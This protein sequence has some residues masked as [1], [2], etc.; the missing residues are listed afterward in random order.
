MKKN[1]FHRH[2]LYACL[3]LLMLLGSVLPYRVA[4]SLGAAI[5]RFGWYVLL[6]RERRKTLEH[7]RLA[8]GN[9]KTEAEL[10]QIGAST[11]DH[12]GR[13][14]AE[15]VK[16]DHLIAHLDHYISVEGYEHLDRGFEAGNGVIVVAAHFGNW[17]LMAGHAALKGYPCSVIARKLYLEQ[18]DRLMMG[19]RRKMKLDM[20]YRTDSPRRMLEVLR[21]NR[22]LGFVVDQAIEDVEVIQVQFFGKPAWTPVAPARF[23]RASGA[24]LIIAYMVREGL[25]HR[26]VVEPPIALADTGDRAA[27]LRANTQ[28][29]VSAQ[30]RFIRR[31]PHLWV[32]NHRRWKE[33]RAS[34]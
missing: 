31:H 12:Y 26:I 15:W 17:E 13:C 10:E 2:L 9:E 18:Y 1:K 27:D 7:L 23:A 28:A 29:W 5:G 22:L 34:G 25:R 19:M 4:V 21:Q 8:F 14:A 16:I 33:I 11:F 30:E 6:P 3:R 20:M 32:W 24:P